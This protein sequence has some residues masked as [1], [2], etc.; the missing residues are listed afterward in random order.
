MFFAEVTMLMAPDGGRLP[1]SQRKPVL[2]G[3][4]TIGE[5]NRAPGSEAYAVVVDLWEQY[6]TARMRCLANMSS[7]TI[8]PT[9]K[10]R[11]LLL[12]GIQRECWHDEAGKL[13]IKEHR[14]V[15]QV[16]PSPRDVDE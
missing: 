8:L 13:R 3:M 7:P 11:G 14:Q 10:A 2:R 15:W 12:S 5:M 4:L 6:G 16:I 9:S 1:P